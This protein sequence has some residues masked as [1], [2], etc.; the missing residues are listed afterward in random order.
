MAV[1]GLLGIVEAISDFA[2][3]E[4]VEKARDAAKPLLQTT[5]AASAAKDP[6]FALAIERRRTCRRT[7]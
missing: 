5:A 7:G 3:A 2:H 6:Q 1:G 4:D